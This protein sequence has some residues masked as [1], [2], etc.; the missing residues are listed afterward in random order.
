MATLLRKSTLAFAGLAAISWLAACRSE[1]KKS[2]RAAHPSA[3]AVAPASATPPVPPPP[4]EPTTPPEP[5]KPQDIT[6]PSRGRMLHGTITRPA[7]AGPFPALIYNHGSERTPG[8]YMAL[9]TFF[10]SHGYV[11]F[12]PYR[13]GHEPSPGPFLGDQ[14]KHSPDR[15]SAAPRLL[16]EQAEDV[17]NAMK[18]LATQPYVDK[19]RVAVGGCSYGGIET[20][21]SAERGFGFKAAVDWAGDAESW[22][23]QAMKQRLLKAVGHAKIPIFFLQAQN[24]HSTEPTRV[25]GGEAERLKKPHKAK[26]YPAWGDPNNHDDGHGGFCTKGMSSWGDDVLQFLEKYD[27]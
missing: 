18:Y 20:I 5:P 6:F 19:E 14:V 4:P 12:V 27:K 9:R 17:G 16:A 24:D 2:A 21:F 13:T 7:G 22:K 25:F 15:A 3:E 11:F 1:T 26:V 8:H 23:N 10:S